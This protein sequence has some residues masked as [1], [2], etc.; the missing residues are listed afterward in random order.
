[1]FFSFT[2]LFSVLGLRNFPKWWIILNLGI[3]LPP[4]PFFS[5]A[6]GGLLDSSGDRYPQIGGFVVGDSGLNLAL[7]DLYPLLHQSLSWFKLVR[8]VLRWEDMGTELGSSGQKRG[9][10]FGMVADRAIRDMATSVPP[11]LSILS[12]TST[13]SR[14]FHALKEKCTLKLDVFNK[15]RDRFQFPDETRVLLY[16]GR[17]R[18]LMPLPMVKF[19]FIKLLFRVA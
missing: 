2:F 3:S 11:S 8:G 17:A 6:W 4:S 16:L 13:T 5:L 14:P 19:A 1:M 12:S 7:G 15:F 9:S 18:R 10:S